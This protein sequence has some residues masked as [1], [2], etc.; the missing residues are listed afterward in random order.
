MLNLD[1]PEVNLQHLVEVLLE[2][3]GFEDMEEAYIKEFALKSIVPGVCIDENCEA[4]WSRC[5]PDMSAGF[6]DMC[7]QQTVY[8][9]MLIMEII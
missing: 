2:D 1:S 7:E 9:S 4:V 6:C 3:E 8:S 5:E